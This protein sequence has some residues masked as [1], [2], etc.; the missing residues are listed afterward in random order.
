MNYRHAYHAGNHTEVFKHSALCLVIAELQKKTTPFAILDTHAGAGEYNLLS[1][2]AMKTG[3]ALEGIGLAFDKCIPS[4]AIYLDIVRKRN[5]ARLSSYPGSPKIVQSLLRQ[6]D[7]L[8]ACEL[9]KDDS[10]HLR[11]MF[12]GDGR[13]S[14]HQRDGYEAIGAFVPL[15]TKRGVVFIDPPFERADEFQ[16]LGQALNAGVAKWPTGIFVA[17][18]PLKDRRGIGALRKQYNLKNPPTLC[19]EFLRHPLD[20]VTLAGS[21]LLICNPPW[22]L[23]QKLTTLCRELS[24]A[25]GQSQAQWDLDWW[26]RER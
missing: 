14:V 21:G 1:P 20:G 22:Q 6:E 25:L 4:A 2:E 16:A 10:S 8:I 17:W 19:C 24:I 26:I 3:E 15:A 23:D 13:I 12:E 7:R 5:S 11:A 18:F 9:R